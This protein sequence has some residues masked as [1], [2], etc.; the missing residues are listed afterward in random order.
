[1][2][3][4]VTIGIGTKYDPS[5]IEK[6]KK[7][8]TSLG[9]KTAAATKSMAANF[10]LVSAGIT[11][12][13]VVFRKAARAVGSLVSAYGEQEDAESRLQGAIIATGREADMHAANI[14]AKMET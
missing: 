14:K 8:V 9:T 2:A 7:G 13:I 4:K 3:K 1:M 10:A 11:G 5:G 12:A 6:A